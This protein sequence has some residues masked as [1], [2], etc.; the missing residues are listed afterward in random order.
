MSTFRVRK[1]F[2]LLEAFLAPSVVAVLSLLLI[3]PPVRAIPAVLVS[4]AFGTW[5]MLRGSRRALTLTD[6]GVQVQRDKYRMDVPW[7]TVVGVDRGRRRG[8][9]RADELILADSRIVA[10]DHRNQTT[11]LPKGLQGHPATSRVQVSLY[12]RDWASGPIGEHL[13]ARGITI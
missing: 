4:L 12:D 11:T 9:V 13:R 5:I 1:P 3:R 6:D 8:L 7:H 10:L 2:A